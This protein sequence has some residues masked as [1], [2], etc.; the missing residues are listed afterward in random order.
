M[1]IRHLVCFGLTA[2]LLGQPQKLTIATVMQGPRFSGYAP[3]A[4]RWSGDSTQIFF[5]WKRYT[6]AIRAPFDT[7]T[8]NRDGSGLKKLTEEETRFAPPAICDYEESR[9]RCVYNQSG[10]V[11]IYDFSAGKAKRLTATTDLESAPRFLPGGSAVSYQRANNLFVHSLDDGSVEQMTDIRT[12]KPPADEEE[13]KK[14]PKKELTSQDFLKQEESNLLATIKDRNALRDEAKARRRRENPRKPYYLASRTVPTNLRLSGDRKFVVAILAQR[15]D[16]AKT[17]IVPNYITDTGYTEDLDARTFVGDAQSKS[18]LAV[19]D[20]ASGEVKNVDLGLGENHKAVAPFGLVLS[21]DASKCLFVLRS[22][23]N[24]DLWRMAL[25]IPT[26][27][28]RILNQDR[29]DAWIGGPGVTRVGFLAGNDTIFFHSEKTG[30]SQLYT[31]PFAGGEARSLT[32]GNFEV[33]DTELSKDKKLFYLTTSEVSPYEHHV[34]SLDP[35]TGA[36]TRLTTAVGR[37]QITLSPDEKWSADVYSFTTRPDELF[38]SENR[39]GATMKQLTTSPSPDFLARKWLETPI[40][41]IP[42]R[43]G[44]K[45]PGRLFKPAKP[46][47]AAVVFVHGAGYAQDVHKWWSANYYRE[48]MFHHILMEAGYTVLDIDYRASSGYGRDWRTGIYRF[49]G[50]KDLEDHLDAAKWLVATQG[51]N[52]KKIGLYG[53]SYGGFITLMALF[54]SPDTFAAGAALRPVTDW[55]HYNHGY[56]SNILNE[57]QKDAEAYRKSSPIYHAEG[58]KGALLI[59]HGMVDVNVHYQ[60]SVRL[61]QRLIEL[62]KDNWEFASFPVEDHAFIEAASWTDEYKRI[63]QLF[64]R[65]LR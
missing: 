10:D 22:T 12:G 36:K 57:P 30:Y 41:D 42:V 29:D 1:K 38:V 34:Y 6:D 56:T 17:A 53:G 43:D 7:Y 18:R 32:A 31:M 45:V 47:G 52:A 8:V 23:D 20:V 65:N 44:K 28:A 63:F 13:P 49:M 24:K 4:V 33:V 62:G 50:G 61:A 64:E 39:P 58:L 26:A 60:D 51:V 14:D 46:N 2:A 19:I 27:K 25:D 40:V 54:T 48:Y 3:T 55:A 59:C 37:H 35:A 21:D 5:Q 9:K 15:P 11:W 16:G